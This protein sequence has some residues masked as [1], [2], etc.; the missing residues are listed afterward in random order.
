MTLFWIIIAIAYLM[1][2]HSVINDIESEVADYK[3]VEF[4]KLE[5][6]SAIILWPFVLVAIWLYEGSIWK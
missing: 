1:I 4:S 3:H 6:F 2:G 5:T